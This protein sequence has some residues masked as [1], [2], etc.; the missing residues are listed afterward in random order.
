MTAIQRH[1]IIC[2]PL[3]DVERL[4]KHN[5]FMPRQKRFKPELGRHCINSNGAIKKGMG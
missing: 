4:T 1:P 2:E 3:T 5:G